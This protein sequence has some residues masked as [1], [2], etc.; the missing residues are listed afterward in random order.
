MFGRAIYVRVRAESEAET[1]VAQ[2]T[3]LLLVACYDQFGPLLV[4]YEILCDNERR[5]LEQK[6]H[7]LLRGRLP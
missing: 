7:G 4:S 2:M 6:S 5:Q 1:S 3:N